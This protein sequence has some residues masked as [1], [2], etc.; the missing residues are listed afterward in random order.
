MKR[1][2]ISFFL[3]V[4]LPVAAFAQ[5]TL[6]VRHDHDPWGGGEGTLTISEQ[7]IEFK[8]DKKEDH[9]RTWN[10]VD[11]QSVDRESPTRFNVLT[12][13]DEKWWLGFDRKFNFKIIGKGQKLTDETMSLISRNLAKPVVDRVAR[14][15]D[16]PYQIP[17]K[18]IHALG[19]CQGTLYIGDKWIVYQ[20]DHR[21]DA[22]RWER[23]RDIVSVWSSDRY[24]LELIVYE[25]NRE[26]LNKTK[27]FRFQLKEPLDRELYDQL[28][29][30]MVVN[31]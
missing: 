1:L 4:I 22:R 25:E 15:I 10:W 8:E 28:R 2:Q 23:D 29:R 12:Y 14:K 13:E 19:G 9:S 20:T 17:V 18:H 30:E 16:A 26:G 24:D 6:R 27:H 7:G 3:F 11:I 5:D 21:E 31:W